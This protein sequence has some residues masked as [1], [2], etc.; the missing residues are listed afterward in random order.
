MA[1]GGSYTV[2]GDRARWIY[3]ESLK[4]KRANPKSSPPVFLPRRLSI[5]SDKDQPIMYTSEEKARRARQ[6]CQAYYY[7]AQDPEYHVSLLDRA[8][9]SLLRCN[10]DGSLD[11]DAVVTETC[12]LLFRPSRTPQL[13]ASL[14]AKVNTHALPWLYF[15][16][17][18]SGCL[19]HELTFVGTMQ[20]YVNTIAQLLETV[21]DLSARTDDTAAERHWLV[22]R[23]FL[24]TCWSRTVMLHF[25]YHLD[26]QLRGGYD[27]ERN[28]FLNMH[29]PLPAY[30]TTPDASENLPEYM[31]SWAFGLLKLDRASIGQDFCDFRSRFCSMFGDKPG[32]VC[33]KI[34]DQSA[35]DFQCNGDYEMMVW[36]EVSYRNI[37]GARAISIM[38]SHRA[39][40]RYCQVSP[41]TL[42]VS[43]VRAH[44]AGGR[45]HTG[46]NACLFARLVQLARVNERDSYWMGTPCI[47]ESHELRSEAVVNINGI[48]T[49]SRMTLIWGR[50]IMSIDIS[51]GSI[52]KMETL[53]SVLL[54]CDR[55]I[56]SWT[57][58][59]SMRARHNVHLLCKDN[60]IV[61]LKECLT[62]VHEKGVIAIANLFLTHQQL[63][64]AQAPSPFDKNPRGEIVRRRDGYISVEESICLLAYRHASRLS[65]SIAIMSLLHD[66]T[67]AYTAEMFWKSKVNSMVHMG[68]L[69]SAHP[70]LRRK[71]FGWASAQPEVS[72]LAITPS[73]QSP[74]LHLAYDGSGTPV[75]LITR[76]G[77]DAEFTTF[78]VFTTS[79]HRLPT[80][81]NLK[82]LFVRN[83]HNCF[84]CP[85]HRAQEGF[86]LHKHRRALFVLPSKPAVTSAMYHVYRGPRNGA[87]SGVIGSDDKA[88]NI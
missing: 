31:C 30:G 45:P 75:A 2:S 85:S 9:G 62:R 79:P 80:L 8:V 29:Q 19:R 81:K 26:L 55:N 35:H 7:A 44:G 4:W 24:W 14:F 18:Q 22:A 40:I 72:R 42:R 17:A 36:D 65:D 32:G 60:K 59:E 78:E 57:L 64:P 3:Q 20:N 82:D 88:R 47:P 51:D 28:E 58:L 10:F 49:V 37:E 41:K 25:H 83:E 50:D 56:R 38:H 39:T 34:I 86:Q 27:A 52:E 54:V 43:H 69:F 73:S 67:P 70:R 77:L 46:M 68:I 15:G 1:E 33:M 12:T 63:L 48:F 5:H 76:D 11:E 23:S 71:G 16:G 53:L 74:I 84:A 87:F 13:P 21:F 61:S 66:T 6:R